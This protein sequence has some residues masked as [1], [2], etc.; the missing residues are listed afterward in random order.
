MLI[1]SKKT[2]PTSLVLGFFVCLFVCLSSSKYNKK[3]FPQNSFL[4]HSPQQ[5]QAIAVL[6]FLSVSQ[7]FPDMNTGLFSFSV[8]SKSTTKKHTE[9]FLL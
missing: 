8:V 6:L 1:Y 3:V 9:M 2:K 7:G 5:D 4:A